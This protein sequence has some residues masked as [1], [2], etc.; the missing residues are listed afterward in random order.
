MK[1]ISFQQV[2]LEKCTVYDRSL[3]AGI[4]H[5]AAGY[6]GFTGG[7]H[8][9]TVLLKPNLISAGGPSLAC[10]HSEFIAGAAIWFLEQ[11]AKVVIGDS[12]AFGSSGRVCEKHSITAALSGLDLSF[13]E[14]TTPVRK[15]LAC[16]RTVTVAQEA[17][18]CDL[19]VGLPKVK[20][21]NQMY[22][23]LAAKNIF[24]IVKG[25]NKAK[26]H[27]STG[28][29]HEQ[30]SHVI[31]DLVPFLPPQLHLMDGIHAMHKSGPLDGV[32]LPLHCV[33]ASKCSVALESA[34][35]D[36][37]GLDKENSPL[38]SAARNKQLPGSYT[39]NLVYPSLVPSDF[40]PSGFVAPE[41]LHPVRFSPLRFF[42]GMAKR[43][44]LTVWG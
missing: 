11:G 17:L 16:G 30:F 18:D 39:E 20:A 4:I 34:L 12:P 3:I 42:S 31:L 19:F 23:T 21:H 40:H 5:D 14:F 32:K 41:S 37:L 6:L 24:G 8:G 2:V 33:A 36:L 15:K 7:F 9:Q 29:S 28:N 38:W 25:V 35:L 43:I 26:L 10:T 27:M 22:V 13:V 1:N 44:G